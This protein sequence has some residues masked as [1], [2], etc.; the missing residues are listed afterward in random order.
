MA[1]V[2]SWEC[3]AYFRGEDG[4][5]ACDTRCQWYHRE[6]CPTAKGSLKWDGKEHYTER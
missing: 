5:G 1:K 3:M 6:G 4:L 2:P